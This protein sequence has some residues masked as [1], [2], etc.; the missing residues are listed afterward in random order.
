MVSD[1]PGKLWKLSF[2]NNLSEKRFVNIINKIA[3]TN[4][5]ML[6]I[7][8]LLQMAKLG[9]ETQLMINTTKNIIK[10]KLEYTMIPNNFFL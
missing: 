7:Y 10:S 6:Q 1:K 4:I 2:G 5:L 3:R 8:I 9:N